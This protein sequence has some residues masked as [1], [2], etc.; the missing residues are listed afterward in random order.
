MIDRLSIAQTLHNL[1]VVGP[2]LIVTLKGAP[3]LP[4]FRPQQ[5]RIERSAIDMNFGIVS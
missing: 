5:E 2:G 4:P 1:L 3:A